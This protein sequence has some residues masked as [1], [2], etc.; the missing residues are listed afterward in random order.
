MGV[1]LTPMREELC[2]D[3]LECLLIHHSAWTFLWEKR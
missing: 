1:R 3:V 2:V